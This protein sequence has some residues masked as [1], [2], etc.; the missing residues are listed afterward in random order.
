M[1]GQ[2]GGIEWGESEKYQACP[3]WHLSRFKIIVYERV[4]KENTLCLALFSSADTQLWF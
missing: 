4:S 2:D 3:K 1:F